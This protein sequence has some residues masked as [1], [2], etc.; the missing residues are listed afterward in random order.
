MKSTDLINTLLKAAALSYHTDFVVIGSS[1]IHGTIENPSIDAVLRTPD[2]DFYPTAT[3]T[4]ILWEELMRELGQ[5][6]DYHMQSGCYLEVV[7]ATLARFPE[8]WENRAKRKII[9]SIDIKSTEQKVNAT[10]PEIHDLTVSKIAIKR[11]KDYE[12]LQ[13][14]IDLGLVD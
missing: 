5:D 10:F 1:A 13:G 9:G 6:S 4:P 7:S 2:V 12:F 8:G 14:V 3:F 11:N